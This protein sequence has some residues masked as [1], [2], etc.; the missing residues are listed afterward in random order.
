MHSPLS[1]PDSFPRETSVLC[2]DQVC[3]SV[4]TVHCSSERAGKGT[5][6]GLRCG[7]RGWRRISK[8]R[9][10]SSRREKRSGG[11]GK[12]DEGGVLYGGR[13]WTICIR[14]VRILR[15]VRLSGERCSVQVPQEHQ[16]VRGP[17]PEPEPT[18]H[19]E[20]GPLTLSQYCAP[21]PVHSSIRSCE[22]RQNSIGRNSVTGGFE[23]LDILHADL[24]SAA[25]Q[26]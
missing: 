5:S 10:R 21:S 24:G 26:C 11:G 22:G 12:R 15:T 13:L 8:C 4:L 14:H 16:K 9:G 17:P 3:S 1:L 6:I 25:F 23:P 19:G 2:W 7:P 18:S 20:W